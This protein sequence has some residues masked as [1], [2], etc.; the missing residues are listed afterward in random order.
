M[1]FT[2]RLLLRPGN[3]YPDNSFLS[4]LYTTALRLRGHEKTVLFESY[5]VIAGSIIG[6][7]FPRT[8]V[9][10]E[11][12]QRVLLR[13]SDEE[14]LRFRDSVTNECNMTAIAVREKRARVHRNYL[15]RILAL[16]VCFTGGNYCP[17]RAHS[18]LSTESKSSTLDG[19]RFLTFRHGRW[20]HVCVLC[21]YFAKRYRQTKPT[22][23]RPAMA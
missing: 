2:G 6:E 23:T 20:L 11:R 9:E 7:L 14:V 10:Y 4:H 17:S 21:L 15:L 16:T 3:L 12:I 8:A 5:G 18:T 13:G 1:S 19:S 22:R